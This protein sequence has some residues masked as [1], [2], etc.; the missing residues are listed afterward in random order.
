M[1]GVVGGSTQGQQCRLP[2]L[3]CIFNVELSNLEKW[4]IF[5]EYIEPILAKSSSKYSTVLIVLARF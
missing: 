5:L 4:E 1:I 3:V 2:K